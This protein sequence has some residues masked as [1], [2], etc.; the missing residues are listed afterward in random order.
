[1]WM[2][3]VLIALKAE[4]GM[5]VQSNDT[6]ASMS[7][8]CIISNDL[9]CHCMHIE[10]LCGCAKL[11]LPCQ[12]NTALTAKPTWAHSDSLSESQQSGM[13]STCCAAGPKLPAGKEAGGNEVAV[14]VQESEPSQ[15][16]QEPSVPLLV[17]AFC[18]G[19]YK[20]ADPPKAMLDLKPWPAAEAKVINM[21]A[22]AR[23]SVQYNPC[24]PAPFS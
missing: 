24:L 17:D 11:L 10:T 9:A 21:Q 18:G 23:R 16:Q 7:S 1:M 6:C 12:R 5:K 19:M 13:C 3:R 2:D 22:S 8:R 20:R 4:T 15:M 14:T